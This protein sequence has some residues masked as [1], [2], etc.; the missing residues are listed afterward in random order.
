MA[1]E[2]KEKDPAC[3]GRAGGCGTEG[4]PRPGPGAWQG[5]RQ[6]G[7]R[8]S[9]I[10]DAAKLCCPPC[11]EASLPRGGN[12]A[13]WASAPDRDRAG[14]ALSGTPLSGPFWPRETSVRL[15]PRCLRESV[16][17]RARQPPPGRGGL[18]GRYLGAPEETAFFFSGSK[19]RPLAPFRRP[20]PV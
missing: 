2:E 7:H 10:L 8:W 1:G 6:L 20:L 16:R 4:R 19:K 18:Q 5:R 3:E 17:F 9:R 11:S 13:A 14:P 15:C 12:A